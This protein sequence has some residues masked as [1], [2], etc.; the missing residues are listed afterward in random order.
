[1]KDKEFWQ[2]HIR[3]EWPDKTQV[4]VVFPAPE[5]NRLLLQLRSLGERLPEVNLDLN[6]S[7]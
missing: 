4:K 3:L 6:V 2:G 1:M 7:Q 5:E